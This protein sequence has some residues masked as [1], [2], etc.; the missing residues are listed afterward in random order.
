VAAGVRHLITVDPSAVQITVPKPYEGNVV[1]L[2]TEIEQL[3]IEPV[4]F[5]CATGICRESS[6]QRR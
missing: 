5:P 6:G 1:A 3:Q 4:R 2:L